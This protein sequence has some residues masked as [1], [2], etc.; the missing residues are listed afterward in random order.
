MKQIILV[1]ILVCLFYISCSDETENNS[2]DAESMDIDP[3]TSV[4]PIDAGVDIFVCK[5]DI[6]VEPIVIIDDKPF[7]KGPYIMY[8]DTTST[9]IMWETETVAPSVVEYGE[10]QSSLDK[11]MGEESDL[12]EVRITGLKPD[13]E[14][15]YRAGDGQNMSIMFK[16]RTNPSHHKPFRFVAYGDSQNHPEIHSK[17]IPMIAARS[18]SFVLHAGDAVE[19]GGE[20]ERWQTEF[21]DVVRPLIF[22]IPYYISIGNHEANSQYFYKYVSYPYPEGDEQHESYYWFKYGAV[23]V[24]VID[25]NKYYFGT[26]D[27][28]H[29]WVINT[30]KRP[31]AVWAGL[32]IALFHEAAYTDGWGTCNYDGNLQVRSSLL[33]VLEKGGVDL[34]INGHTH[35][36]ERGFLNGVYHMIVGGGGGDLDHKCND[37]EFI[38]KTNYVHH[39]ISADV[40]C[41]KVH[42]E[43]VDIDGN[44]FD[45]F[46]IPFSYPKPAK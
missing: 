18:P 16:F 42:I 31:E 8:T 35:G 40:L 38:Q 12:H 34:I 37:F 27:P 9:T 21:F 29:R 14:Y 36:Y 25:S 17:L 15:F 23:F 26:E 20:E 32:R 6:G 30:L 1:G 28:Q 33:P 13:T 22:Y 3:D 5:N 45:S 19:R 43:A 2:T 7:K 24:I 11:V 10:K 44:V 4:E 46:D 41:D 39:F